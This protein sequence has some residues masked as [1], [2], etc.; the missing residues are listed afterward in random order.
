MYNLRLPVATLGQLC[1]VSESLN[2]IRQLKIPGANIELL[3]FFE[4][5]QL[6]SLE[7]DFTPQIE[8]AVPFDGLLYRHRDLPALPVRGID[9]TC[10]FSEADPELRDFSAVQEALTRI[11]HEGSAQG[12]LTTLE[13]VTVHL[14][15]LAHYE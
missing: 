15:D 6:Q 12:D 5:R 9:I 13:V 7:L 2:A 14:K 8:D 3:C 10:G 4:L 11:Q 1:R